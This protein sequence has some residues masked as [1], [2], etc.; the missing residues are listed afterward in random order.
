MMRRL[1]AAIAAAAGFAALTVGCGVAVA[2]KQYVDATATYWVI[3]HDRVPYRLNVELIASISAVP[4]VAVVSSQ[5]FAYLV[6]SSTRCPGKKC[7]SASTYTQAL[8]DNQYDNADLKKIW[9][10]TGAYGGGLTITWASSGPSSPLDLTP[11]AGTSGA[12]LSSAWAAPAKIQ[13]FGTTCVDAAALASRHTHASP[14][15]MTTPVGKPAP[16]KTGPGLPPGPVKCT[17]APRR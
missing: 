4:T 1:V 16:F 5:K 6:V 13:V 15:A 12:D 2:D 17:T 8:V 10:H 3:G 11:N 14:N 9:A 7:G